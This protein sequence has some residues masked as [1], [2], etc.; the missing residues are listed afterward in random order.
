MKDPKIAKKIKMGEKVDLDKIGDE[1]ILNRRFIKEEGTKNDNE[2]TKKTETKTTEGLTTE[3]RDEIEEQ[4]YQENRK[5]DQKLDKMEIEHDIY[6]AL[7][8][9]RK[10]PI[11]EDSQKRELV[12]LVG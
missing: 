12:I 4:R 3:G 6:M 9:F 10:I 7:E 8:K 2:E 11:P 5:V 1:K